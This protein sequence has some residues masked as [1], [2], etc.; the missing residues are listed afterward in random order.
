M[1]GGLIV[2]GLVAL[3][4]FY[5]PSSVQTDL[6]TASSGE[7]L[8]SV[9]ETSFDFG[10]ISMAKGD[11]THQF[12][13]KNATTTPVTITKLYTSCMCTSAALYKNENKI[14]GPFGMAGHGPKISKTLGVGEE[15]IV[16]ETFDPKA[17]GPAGI[18]QIEREVY[19]ETENGSPLILSFKANVTP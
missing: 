7:V 8:L 4:I 16:L 15:M 19:L 18:G 12:K 11:V 10:T 13:I 14:A 2:V 17:H 1:F 6:T 9:A 3:V 5:R